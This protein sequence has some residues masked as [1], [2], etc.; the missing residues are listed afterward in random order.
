VVHYNLPRSI[1]GFYQVGVSGAWVFRVLPFRKGPLGLMQE[2]LC[3]L[4]AVGYSH[5]RFGTCTELSTHYS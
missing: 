1:E 5:Y 3:D 4:P 2:L